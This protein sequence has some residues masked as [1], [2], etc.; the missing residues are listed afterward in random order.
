[1][2]GEYLVHAW[3]H[4]DL[5]SRPHLD[6]HN[7]YNS[8]RSGRYADKTI[9]DPAPA[10][11]NKNGLAYTKHFCDILIQETSQQ[12]T[13]TF[14]KCTLHS[15]HI[16]LAIF[17]VETRVTWLNYICCSWT[18]LSQQET[19]QSVCVN[20]YHITVKVKT[21]PCFWMK[22]KHVSEVVSL[23]QNGRT[24]FITRQWTLLAATR[25]TSKKL[26]NERKVSSLF[27][28]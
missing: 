12:S 24:L 1:M 17:I 27:L 14:S 3:C 21:N 10:K 2:M 23:L 6:T 18:L 9:N 25:T 16:L 5:A 26:V 11:W 13:H 15:L 4:I 20:L 28:F 22:T 7:D 19:G 8:P